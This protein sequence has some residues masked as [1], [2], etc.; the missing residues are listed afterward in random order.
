MTPP[1]CPEAIPKAIC[2]EIT[3]PALRAGIVIS[4]VMIGKRRARVFAS[5]KASREDV[6]VVAVGIVA[7]DNSGAGKA[8]RFI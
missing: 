4:P 6:E 5:T 1:I 8:L 2:G 3:M 7:L